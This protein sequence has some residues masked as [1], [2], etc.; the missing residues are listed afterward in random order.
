M[1]WIYISPHLDDVVLSLGGLIWEQTTAGQDVSIWT[2]CAGD[3]PPGK[4][5]SFAQ[6]LHQ[7]WEVGR[8]AIH[9][10]R[11]EDI[12]SCKRLGA[13]YLHF[14]IPDCIYRRSPRTGNFLYDSESSLW[15]EVHPDESDR[16]EDLSRKLREIVPVGA[17]LVCPITIG[18]HVDHRFTRTAIEAAF[19][20]ETVNL[21]YYPDYPYV[22][23][24]ALPLIKDGLKSCL[25]SLSPNAILAWQDAIAHH[26]S[27]IS[28]FWESID[29]MRSAIQFYYEKMGGIWLG[30]DQNISSF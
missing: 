30:S 11:D 13:G 5:S 20:G 22:L 8:D 15:G 27:Q 12:G 1:N 10:R 14:D 17:N 21:Y 6:S 24:E 26:Q 25:Y 3:P 2:I 29:E 4:L 9:E 28:T 7:R 23:N 16:I 19:Q 18:H